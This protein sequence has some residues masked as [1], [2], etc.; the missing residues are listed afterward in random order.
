MAGSDKSVNRGQMEHIRNMNP[1]NL[2]EAVD[3]P[4]T[5]E[6][7]SWKSYRKFEERVIRYRRH[8]W[9][10]AIG[11]FLDTVMRTSQNRA[12]EIPKGIILW[13]AQL[14]VDY[15]P[16]RDASG[17]EAGEE[18]M[19]LS[20]TRMQ[21]IA[22][23]TREGR[24]NSSGIPVLYLASTERTAISEVRPWVGSE[25]SVAQF[26][27]TRPLNAIDL[28]PG[29][30]KPSWSGLT[31]NQLWGK[32]EVNAEDKAKAVWNDIDNAFSKPVTLHDEREN[33]VPTRIL[34]ELFREAGYD[35]I[36]YRSQFGQDGRDGFNIAVF[37]LEDAEILNCAP[38]SVESIEVNFKDSGHRWYARH[39]SSLDGD[40]GRD[41]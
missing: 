3:D 15:V 1:D 28:T 25:V 37:K 18:P 4:Q 27:V 12:A 17:E 6:F 40:N 9:D 35:A 41:A 13:R 39:A 30:G 36:V 11:A 19:G 34:A 32:E 38:Y 26:R 20:G 10:R 21:P 23:Y 31:L 8:I 5:P 2:T 33:Y 22:E 7:A 14:G 29:H 16:F 24:A